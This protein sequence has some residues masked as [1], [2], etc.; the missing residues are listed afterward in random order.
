MHFEALKP[1]A[2]A[3]GS[4]AFAH[5]A[6]FGQMLLHRMARLMTEKQPVDMREL[7]AWYVSLWW[8]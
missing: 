8:Y 4:V 1:L 6:F 2:D 5:E 7:H 3:L